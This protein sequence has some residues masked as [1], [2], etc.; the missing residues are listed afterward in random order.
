MKPFI[1]RT[2]ALAA[3]LLLGACT[4]YQPLD[5]GS[6]VP[7]A[8]VMGRGGQP[9]HAVSG[10]VMTGDRERI[11]VQPVAAAEVPGADLSG[12]V[13]RV[14]RGE[15]LALLARRY[16]V[17]VTELAAINRLKPPYTIYVGQVLRLPQGSAPNATAVASADRHTVRRGENLTGIARTY[18]VSMAAIVE[19]NELKS[20]DAIFAGQKLRLPQPVATQLAARAEA[21]TD[22][23]VDDSGYLWPVK[24]KLI[25]R[26][27]RTTAGEVRQGIAIAA[28][29]GTPVRAA[30]TGLVVYAGD[31]IRGYGRMVLLRHDDGYVTAYAHN[32]ALLVNV[33]ETVERGEVIARVGDTGGVAQAQLHFEIRKGRQPI[34]PETVLAD[35]PTALASSQ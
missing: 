25:G 35:A 5:A 17:T 6:S 9:V 29:K 22:A 20:P 23:A 30:Q 31:A 8:P 14:E 34:D 26:F 4:A 11:G 33:G 19:L 12:R 21:G 32:S 13:H 24:G 28:R 18:G 1:Y 27:G 3:A 16:D 2:G 7:W 15:A 10:V